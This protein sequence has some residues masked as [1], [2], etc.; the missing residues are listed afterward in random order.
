[1]GLTI[2]QK[3]DLLKKKENPKIALVLAGG[4]VA[5]GAYKIGGLKALNDFLINRKII[6]RHL[7]VAMGTFE[8]LLT[9]ANVKPV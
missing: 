3:S 6:S 7:K 9:G 5:G 8:N 2:V 1:M 4:A